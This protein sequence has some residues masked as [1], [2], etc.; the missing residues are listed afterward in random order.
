MVRNMELRTMMSRR[1]KFEIYIDILNE[2]KRNDINDLDEK[3][4]K[5]GKRTSERIGEKL[6]DWAKEAKVNKYITFH[7][8]RHTFATLSLNSGV[9]LY[10]VSKLLGHKSITMTEIYANIINEKADEKADKT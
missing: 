1:S 10:T 3:I 8:A 4:F 5:L 2:I 9:D 6:R 7:T